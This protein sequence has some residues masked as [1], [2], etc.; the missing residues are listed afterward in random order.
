M[1]G[2]RA[3]TVVGP[4]GD[5]RLAGPQSGV[6]W[7]AGGA[8]LEARCEE[9]HDCPAHECRCGIHGWHPG[10]R[11]AQRALASRRQVP[12]IV[13]ATGAIEVHED[14]F[15]AQRGRPYAFVLAPCG[16]P[17]RVRRLADAYGV[18][19][20]E[21]RRPSELPAWCRERGLGL[22]EDVV[23][24]MLGP[25]AGAHA[26]E[27]LAQARTAAVGV[28]ALA[29]IVV[30]LLLLGISHDPRGDRVLFGRTGPIHVHH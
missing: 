10:R 12:G 17:A 4:P 7:P 3:W 1:Y 23:A 30:I 13:E 19:V 15:R 14:G 25:A 29:A 26:R 8:W 9:G 5:E 20:L 16:N 28:A 22:Q 21:V 27:R 6:A 24:S 18:P 11:G 2:L